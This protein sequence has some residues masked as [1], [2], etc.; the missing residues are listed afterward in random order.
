MNDKNV[1]IVTG[2]SRG[3]GRAAAALFQ[4]KG[5]IV[6]ALSRTR[7]DLEGVNPI[8]CDVT[9]GVKLKNAIEGVFKAEKRIDV[10][11]NN[12]GGGISG[13][14]EKTALE[15]ARRLFDLNFFAYFEAIKYAVP[16]MRA[17]KS[18]KIINVGS[19]AGTMHFPFQA[20]YSAS[21]AAVEALSNSLRGE[22]DPFNIKVSAIL[23]GDTCTS[24]TEAREKEFEKNDPDYGERIN[25]SI[26][27]MEKGERNG[28][29]SEKVAQK[30]YK[31]VRSK[32]PRPAY[33]VGLSYNLLV[34]LD[35][36]CPKRLV[37]FVINSMYA[38]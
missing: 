37:Q 22:L 10:L 20:F 8:I 11:V 31:A 12:A 4:K 3:I 36:I 29:P 34:F 17:G 1:I 32:N 27:L 13:A 19:V 6:Y 15:D 5:F 38:K 25:R 21:K 9:D 18:G 7:C 24:F 33:T 23:P 35:K 30:I 26:S 2:A 14:V 28:M 16:F